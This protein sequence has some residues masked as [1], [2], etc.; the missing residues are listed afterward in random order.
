[1]HFFKKKLT[2]I[3]NTNWVIMLAFSKSYLKK[4][5]QKKTESSVSLCVCVC[6]LVAQI[7]SPIMHEL[8]QP[9]ATLQRT[10]E[11]QCRI[12]Y[13]AWQKTHTH[14]QTPVGKTAILSHVNARARM[15]TSDRSHRHTQMCTHHDTTTTRHARRAPNNGYSNV[16][17]KHTHP[18]THTNTHT[19]TRMV[20]TRTTR[21][22]WHVRPDHMRGRTKGT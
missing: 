15:A 21:P 9:E 6:V 10:E 13:W 1:M 19:L 7:K 2:Q 16:P 11:N 4:H 3:C 20:L 8:R 14:I 17:D 5:F 18:Q 22:L 12:Q